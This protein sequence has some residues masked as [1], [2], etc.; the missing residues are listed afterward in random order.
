EREADAL[1]EPAPGTEE[2]LR[3]LDW[4][5]LADHELRGDGLI[6]VDRV[7]RHDFAERREHRDRIDSVALGGS[8]FLGADG[9]RHLL[10]LRLPMLAALRN[11]LLITSASRGFGQHLQ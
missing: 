1:A 11:H 3:H 6:D 8:L 5:M 4:Q 10:V 9:F 7:L 2:A